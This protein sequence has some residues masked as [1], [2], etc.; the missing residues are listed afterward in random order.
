[1]VLGQSL[2]KDSVVSFRNKGQPQNEQEWLLRKR[3]NDKHKT[4][5]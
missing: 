4:V 5:T 3:N 2:R 1:M